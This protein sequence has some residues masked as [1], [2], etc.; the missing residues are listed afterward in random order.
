[1]IAY[2]RGLKIL[3]LLEKKE[4]ST[5]DEILKCF[6]GASES[7]IRRD[8]KKLAGEGQIT[9]VRGGGVYLNTDSYEAPVK[10]KTNQY[11]DAKEMIA[12]YAAG[13]VKEGDSVYIDSG[14]TTLQM[15]KYIKN[16]N[17]N[18]VTSNILVYSELQQAKAQCYILGGELNVDTASVYG[19]T[20][21]EF[22]TQSYFDKAFIG[23]SGFSEKVGINTPDMRE[24]IKKQIVKVQS[25][26]TYVLADSSKAGKNTMC[27]IY[28][29]GEVA[30]I[31]DKEVELLKKYG[32]YYIAK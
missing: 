18:I 17:I 32:N 12:K 2:E 14:S 8:L 21:N 9:L 3:E 6:E 20:T 7:T 24:A 16:M 5:L 30:I 13:F 31:C 22:L 29:L 28:E 23:V 25:A 1:M 15:V 10:A 26:E 4:V 27:K 19:T 11:M